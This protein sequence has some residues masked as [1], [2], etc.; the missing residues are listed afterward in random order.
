MNSSPEQTHPG[1]IEGS[2][3]A[4]QITAVLFLGTDRRKHDERTITAK[5]VQQAADARYDAFAHPS[6]ISRANTRRHFFEEIRERKGRL[7]EV[8]LHVHEDESGAGGIEFKGSRILCAQHS[9][10]LFMLRHGLSSSMPTMISEIRAEL[11]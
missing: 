6:K 10:N 2:C 3:P 9:S 4:R 7:G 5:V 1:V 8:T 11:F